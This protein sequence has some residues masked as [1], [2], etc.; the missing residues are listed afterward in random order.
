MQDALVLPT[1]V[2]AQH[3]N[4]SMLPGPFSMPGYRHHRRSRLALVVW[5]M[6]SVLLLPGCQAAPSQV[7]FGASFPDWMFCMLGGVILTV[8]THSIVKRYD[9]LH[10]LVPLP[11]S[12]I[13]ITTI[14]GVLIWVLAFQR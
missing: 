3:P 13:A 5:I 8:A 11:I 10:W 1:L 4:Q 9:K 14:Y 12:Y 2:G 6:F 7:L